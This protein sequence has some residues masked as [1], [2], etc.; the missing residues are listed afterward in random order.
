MLTALGSVRQIAN[1]NAQVTYTSAYDPYGVVTQASGASQTAY[2]YTN[3]YTSQGL[4]YLRARYYAPYLNQFIQPDTIVPDPRI[5]ADWNKYTYVRDNPINYTDPTG[6]IPENEHARKRAELILE[7]LN[8]IYGVHI[9]KDWGYL[10]EF[11]DT[12]NLYIDPSM[13]CQWMPGNWRSVHELELVLDAVKDMAR[14]LGTPERFKTAMNHRPVRILRVPTRTYFGSAAMTTVGEIV[15]IPNYIFGSDE[16]AKGTVVH[17]L[18]HVWDARQGSRL[19]NSMASLTNSW[20]YVCVHHKQ[21]ESY[22]HF[23]YNPAS[24]L[25]P[26][27]YSREAN[28]KEDWAESFMI[29]T[30][31]SFKNAGFVLGPIRKGYIEEII[32]NFPAYP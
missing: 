26:T 21:H 18:A 5:P 32:K 14:E 22:C 23:E 25:G 19:S 29:F 15:V 10:N 30:Y 12:N 17:E 9:K 11:A 20:K 3:E 2:G 13:G 1:A 31:P 8:T 16:G 4:V 24:E 28:P 7:K 6:H 27:P